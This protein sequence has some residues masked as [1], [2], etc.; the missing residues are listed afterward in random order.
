MPIIT[1]KRTNR[2][3]RK[4]V[5][6][7]RF[8]A[9]VWNCQILNKLAESQLFTSSWD[10]YH[11][12]L[13]DIKIIRTSAFLSLLFQDKPL[14]TDCSKANGVWSCHA[15]RGQRKMTMRTSI[16]YAFCF[17]RY[18]YIGL[19]SDVWRKEV[20]LYTKTGFRGCGWLANGHVLLTWAASSRQP[21]QNRRT[22]VFD[23]SSNS[24]NSVLVYTK[25]RRPDSKLNLFYTHLHIA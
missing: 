21:T 23:W 16:V 25:R 3:V 24:L 12:W 20:K 6:I 13:S 5:S 17:W 14:F 10:K 2:S 7:Y 11:Q 19:F 18:D 8:Q 15:T 4:C 9:V 1:T 22:Y